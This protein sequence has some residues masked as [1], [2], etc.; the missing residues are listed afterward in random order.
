MVALQAGHAESRE[1]EEAVIRAVRFQAQSL[2]MGARALDPRLTALF[3]R[4]E[5]RPE[6]EPLD[7]DAHDER[8][9]ARKEQGRED[10]DA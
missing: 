1:Q 10:S 3:A 4:F 2:P 8:R 5:A 9:R 7:W 6:G